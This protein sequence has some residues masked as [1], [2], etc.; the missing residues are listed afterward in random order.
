MCSLDDAV[1]GASFSDPDVLIN[2]KERVMMAAKAM[3]INDLRFIMKLISCKNLFFG[4]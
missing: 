2:E 4:I 1:L 3:K